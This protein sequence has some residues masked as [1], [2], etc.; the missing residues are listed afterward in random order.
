MKNNKVFGKLVLLFVIILNLTSNAQE[1]S[2]TNKIITDINNLISPNTNI[3][4]KNGI[5]TVNY[6]KNNE[7]I[8]I[9]KLNIDYVIPD[10]ISYSSN[11]KQIL[12]SCQES[13]CTENEFF[14]NIKKK[15]FT[16]SL[17]IF[18]EDTIKGTEV[19]NLFK[20]VIGE[21]NKNNI[22]K[23]SS[24]ALEYKLSHHLISTMPFLLFWNGFGVSYEYI[25]SNEKLGIYIPYSFRFD[26]LF[27]ETG[28][29][30]KFYTGNNK[31]Y[32]YN[33]G[34]LYLGVM[35]TR[36]YWGP[37]FLYVSR[38]DIE[39]PAIRFQNGVSFQ[40]KKHIN[41]TIHGGFG[42]GYVTKEKVNP[43][44]NS[45]KILFDWNISFNLGYRF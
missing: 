12:F 7:I 11:S 34:T 10:D 29:S 31:S 41:F 27:Y 24:P 45:G 40:S 20:I 15:T 25:T 38:N 33:L 3:I 39:Y 43:E 23:I 4:I 21:K 9:S 44:Y 6:L 19:K 36:Y 30:L 5:L 17:K 26:T 8:K 28:L 42:A 16:S 18:I 2:E 32:T 37:E 14:G 13:D 1:I 22:T 35:T